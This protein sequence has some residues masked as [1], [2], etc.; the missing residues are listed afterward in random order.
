MFKMSTL[1]KNLHINQLPLDK[2]SLKEKLYL[3]SCISDFV[4]PDWVFISEL[5]IK[6]CGANQNRPLDWF[7]KAN[8]ASQYNQ[9]MKNN[10]TTHFTESISN[11]KKPTTGIA[12]FPEKIIL[13]NLLDERVRELIAEIHIAQEVYL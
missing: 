9:I 8:C 4:N 5:L 3:I 6:I 13:K 1:E 12:T 7:S 11:S 2:W 10:D